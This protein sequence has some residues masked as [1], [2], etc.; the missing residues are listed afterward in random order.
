[1][2]TSTILIDS[3]ILLLI[4]WRQ[5]M[6]RPIRSTVL[7]IILIV[8]GFVEFMAYAKQNPLSPIEII[9]FIV[10]LAGPAAG[11]GYWRGSVAIRLWLDGT[12]IMQRGTWLNI[13]LWLFALGLHLAIDMADSGQV[14]SVSL[15]LYFGVSLGAQRLAV[16]QRAKRLFPAHV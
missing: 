4:L 5:S 12:T 10:S 16:R 13:L 6:T 15:L 3:V 2:G 7:P 11:I 14:A 8:L 9:L 1:M